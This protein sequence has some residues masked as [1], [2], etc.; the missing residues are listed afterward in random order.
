MPGRQVFPLLTKR[1]WQIAGDK[2]NLFEPGS[3]TAKTIKLL[4]AYNGGEPINLKKLF[5]QEHCGPKKIESMNIAISAGALFTDKGWRL[6]IAEAARALESNGI[7]IVREVFNP[8]RAPWVGPLLWNSPNDFTWKAFVDHCRAC[9]L[10]MLACRRSLF[11]GEAV[12][13]RL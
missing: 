13:I 3:V 5:S 2:F 7:F 11:L 10:E 12:F 1:L 6:S 9:G 8:S 4:V